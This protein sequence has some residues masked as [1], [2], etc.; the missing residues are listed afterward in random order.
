MI[1][2]EIKVGKL[3]V[4]HNPWVIGFEPI[5]VMF[6]GIKKRNN[7]TDKT[8]KWF[9]VLLPSGK[10]QEYYDGIFELKEFKL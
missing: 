6:L 2:N 3:C 8:T 1:M 10:I 5:T 7:G 9:Q 4:L